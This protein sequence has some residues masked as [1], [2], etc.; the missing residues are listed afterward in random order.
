MKRKGG[1]GGGS[2]KEMIF[3]PLSHSVLVHLCLG[4]CS[5][6]TWSS[7]REAPP[8][9]KTFKD[10]PSVLGGKVGTSDVLF[11]P[12]GHVQ[13]YRPSNQNDFRKAALLE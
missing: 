8:P 6:C 1:V 9:G 12:F 13:T 4:P 2:G 7:T 3:K 10:N 5:L 11:K